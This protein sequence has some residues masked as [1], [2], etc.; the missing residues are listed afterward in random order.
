MKKPENTIM[1]LGPTSCN[2]RIGIILSL[3]RQATADIEK[4]ENKHEPKS[5]RMAVSLQVYV[6]PKTF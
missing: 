4:K 1:L 5:F 6:C 2:H 3:Q